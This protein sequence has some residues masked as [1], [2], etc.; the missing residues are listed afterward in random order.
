MRVAALVLAA[1]AALLASLLSG[2]G[3]RRPHAGEG[4]GARRPHAATSPHPRRAGESSLV[5]GLDRAQAIIDDPASSPA[6]LAEAG[7]LEQSSTMTL[8][9]RGLGAERAALAAVDSPAR[10]SLRADLG[11]AGELARLVAPHKALP[12]W[13]IVD[14]PRPSTLLGYFKAA[15]LRYRVPWQDLAAIEFV[16]TKFGRVQGTSDAGAQGPMQFL[17]STWA[18][19]GHGSIRNPRDA[20]NAAARYLVAS[21]A[22][23]D[24][25]GALYHYNPS[26]HY[27][28]AV[29][30]YAGWMRADSRAYYGYYYWRVIFDLRGRSV[31]LPLGYPRT[32]PIP[33]R[34]G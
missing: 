18:T 14:P 13:R 17:P 24:M 20:I 19:Y 30:D 8:A 22:P 21:G 26:R 5:T 23:A 6:Q 32:R 2:G 4:G 29:E 27:V 34:Y 11:A 7:W 15:Q 1:V 9:R 25:A 28:R 31:I 10:G 16:E 33:L 3:A 12:P